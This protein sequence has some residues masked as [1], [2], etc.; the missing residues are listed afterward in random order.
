[1]KHE[2]KPG[3]LALLIGAGTANNFKTVELL[4]CFGSPE[5]IPFGDIHLV[6]R[7]REIIWLVRSLNAPI[8]FGK[9]IVKAAGIRESHESP[10]AEAQLMPLR[11]NENPD[12]QLATSAPRQA[13]TA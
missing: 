13:V 1:M 4:S 7:E 8:K 12:A 5:E 9:E 6:N 11:G 2:F 10:A 3:D